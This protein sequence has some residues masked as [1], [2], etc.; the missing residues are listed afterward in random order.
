VNIEKERGCKA[1]GETLFTWTWPLALETFFKGSLR[2]MPALSPVSLETT[3]LKPLIWSSGRGIEAASLS[4][5]DPEDSKLS[6]RS[7]MFP[8]HWY[9][10]K[11]Q[12]IS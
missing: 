9:N 1:Q 12:Q 2:N 11:Q 8:F 5:S 6:S 4:Q 10:F 3:I 7:E